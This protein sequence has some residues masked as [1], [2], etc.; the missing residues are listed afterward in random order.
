[1]PLEFVDGETSLI[2]SLHGFGGN[3]ADHAAYLP[4]HERVNTHGFALLLPNGTLHGEG[5]PFW[6]PTDRC[7][8]A[9]KTG[10][11]DI[12]YLTDLVAEAEK[13]GDYGPV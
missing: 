6:N 2:V 4:L 5:Y 8:N 13:I 11:D 9:G 1:M 7:C 3:S 10:E 12:A